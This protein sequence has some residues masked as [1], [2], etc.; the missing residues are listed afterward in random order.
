MEKLITISESHYLEIISKLNKLMDQ[1]GNNAL[2]LGDWL[3]EKQTKAIL[4]KGT[5]T[6][7]EMRRDG[8]VAHT[9]FGGSRYYSLKSI[10][11]AMENNKVE[12]YR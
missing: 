2:H 4:Q 12:A 6:L 10:L 5:T 1:V 11:K 7:W 8:Y 9:K 3:T